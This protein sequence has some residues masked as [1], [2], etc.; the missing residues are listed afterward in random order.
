MRTIR[1]YGPQGVE[2]ARYDIVVDDTQT[3][4][5]DA[6]VPL[7][8]TIDWHRDLAKWVAAG[9]AAVVSLGLSYWGETTALDARVLFT[10]AAA[11]LVIALGSAFAL[12]TWI[13]E[14]AKRWEQRGQ[15]PQSKEL[16]LEENRSARVKYST[17]SW[18]A[19][20]VMILSFCGG[21][22]LFAL[23]C[24]VRM[25]RAQPKATYVVTHGARGELL[26]T[27]TATGE[28]W[29]ALPTNKGVVWRLSVPK[30]GR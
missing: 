14:L 10:C 26:L 25:W 24:G 1:F 2:V 4:E 23:A 16:A 13:I 11:F 6:A 12:H 17:R 3:T 5:P 22:A 7:P 8:A 29:Q 9:A 18:A 20:W 28:T 15:I 30:R 21:I 19:Y 27:D